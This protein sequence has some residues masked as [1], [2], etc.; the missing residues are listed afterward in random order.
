MWVAADLTW[1]EA[2]WF[3]LAWVDEVRLSHSHREVEPADVAALCCCQS[4]LQ[5][6]IST[7]NDFS[8]VAAYLRPQLDFENQYAGGINYKK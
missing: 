2:D 6:A 5:P 3:K 1:V 8:I 7:I 4:N